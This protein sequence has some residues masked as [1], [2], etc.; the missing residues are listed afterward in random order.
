MA[1]PKKQDVEV[2]EDCRIM[3]KIVESR[4][5]KDSDEESPQMRRN[6]TH[7]HKIM[8]PSTSR[9]NVDVPSLLTKEKVEERKEKTK[10]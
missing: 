5:Y 2:E 8:K 3:E 7:E 6:S 4:L 9:K 1:N 10:K